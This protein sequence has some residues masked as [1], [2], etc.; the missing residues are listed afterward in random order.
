MPLDALAPLVADQLKKGGLWREEYAGERR[1]W[2]LR[3]IDLLRARYRTAADFAE[4]GRPYV[5]DEFEYEPAAVKKNLKD[6]RLK[7]LLPG[8]SLRLAALQE[9]THDATEA[10]LRAYSEEQGVK[11]GLLIN[12][13]RT[14][15]TGQAV[16]PGMFDIM[17]TLGRDSTVERLNRA[18]ALV[19]Q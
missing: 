14:A 15:L 10:A 4:L 19:G 2:F 9:F 6:E 12:A 17:T 1:D 7:D 3:T 8:F 16:G 13:A 5:S 11:A 18:V